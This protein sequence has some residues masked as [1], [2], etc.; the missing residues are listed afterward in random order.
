MW[1]ILGID[2]RA[3]WLWWTR[4]YGMTLHWGIVISESVFILFYRVCSLSA[5]C[6]ALGHT[7]IGRRLFFRWPL[8]RG[9]L[10]SVD[11]GFFW[12][13]AI[14]RRRSN[15]LF[16]IGAWDMIDIFHLVYFTQGH[17]LSQSMMV[18]RHIC[19]LE[20]IEFLSHWSTR[21]DWVISLMWSQKHSLLTIV[22][23][24][25]RWLDQDT[26]LWEHAVEFSHFKDCLILGHNL[27]IGSWS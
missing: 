24:F 9:R 16:H 20:V 19:S 5:W 7:F 15:I 26:H 1:A 18:L 3:S 10:L 23:R 21:Y 12:V 22:D 11:D 13:M 8:C 6:I 2:S 27:F 25:L 14:P 17:S 4:S